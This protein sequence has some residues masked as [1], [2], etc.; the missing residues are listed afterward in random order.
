[1]GS[2]AHAAPGTGGVVERAPA[3]TMEAARGAAASPRFTG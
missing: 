3:P 2:A 1:M